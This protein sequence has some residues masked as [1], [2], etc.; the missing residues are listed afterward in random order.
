M[1]KIFS[2]AFFL[3]FITIA[4]KVHSQQIPDN[5]TGRL[6]G[7]CKVWGYMK[8]YH[9]NTCQVNWDSL[10]LE[11]STLVAAA[12][13]NTQYN[14]YMMD[15]LNNLGQISPQQATAPPAADSNLNLQLD[16]IS[17]S[18]FSQPVQTF[19]DTFKSRAGTNAALSCRLRFNDYT[20]PDYISYI[21]FIEDA[22][23]FNPDFTRLKDR[24]A[25]TFNYWNVFNYFGPYRKLID[26]PWDSTLMHAIDDM[27]AATDHQSYML[28][29]LKMQSRTNDA[30]GFFTSPAYNSYFGDAAVGI[31]FRWYEQKIVVYKI[32]QSLSGLMVGDELVAID[33]E[34]VA[35]VAARYRDKVPASNE[36]TFYR[37]L[38][39]LLSRARFNTN[40]VLK[41]KNSSGSL[42]T[43][44]VNYSLNLS[45]WFSWKSAVTNE[46]AWR[47]VCNGYGYVNMGKLEP[48]ECEQ[49]YADLK[50]KP[51]IIFDCRNYPKGAMYNIAKY[52]FSEPIISA[53]YFK[54]DL[55]APG[56]FT[57]RDDGQNLG[58]WYNPSPYAGQVY[59]IVDQETQSH[60]EYTVQYLG[61]APNAQVIGTQTAGADGNTAY[62]TFPGPNN[63]SPNNIYFTSLGWYYQDWYQCQRN[64]IKINTVVAPTIQGLR[65]GKDEMLE[66]ITGCP[67]SVQ[68]VSKGI[69]QLELMPNPANEQLNIRFNATKNMT[70]KL[71]LTDLIGSVKLSQQQQSAAGA[72]NWQ[73]PVNDLVPGIYFL[74]MISNDG[75]SRTLKFVKQ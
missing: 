9:P 70:I 18:N 30:H 68:T 69:D 57:V 39:V 45:T 73:L 41:L 2:T 64:G 27:I 51:G 8:Y 36:A 47:T 32:H 42:Y 12:T 58:N 14:T 7:L 19:L 52:L 11:N 6:W 25:F 22:P 35:D 20:I 46:P 13:T 4:G 38:C 56:L 3:G 71:I 23:D 63:T 67:T 16:W 43:L 62:V 55:I 1:K 37:D 34:P 28:S 54:A 48:E 24:L 50:T 66:W 21:D 26:I 65:D 60:A 53:R 59:F 29:L 15:M 5:T 17:Q 31:Q 75:A 10:I 61:Q 49:M 33:G 74:T 44:P 40:K 72:N